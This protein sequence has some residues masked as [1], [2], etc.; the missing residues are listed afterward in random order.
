MALKHTMNLS[1]PVDKVAELLCSEAYNLRMQN[2]RKDVVEARFMPLLDNDT[3]S[4]Y[5]VEVTHY[6][7][8]KTG[9]LDRSVTEESVTHYRFDKRTKVLHWR[10][11]GS[12]GPR[13]DVHGE[14]HF[15]PAGSGTRI[16]RD[17]TIRIDVPI[18]GRGL[19]K[20]VEK[21]FRK[22]FDDIE[23]VIREMLGEG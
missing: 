20:L 21:E 23:R 16:E 10:H 4:T 9:K 7:R 18:V 8:K 5:E 22:G 3:Q 15:H 1:S 14:T 2:D 12:E 17:V 11:E 19:A 6:K 13:V